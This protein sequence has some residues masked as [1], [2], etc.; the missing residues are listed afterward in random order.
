MVYCPL[1]RIAFFALAL[2]MATPAWAWPPLF[3]PEFTF[4]NPEIEAGSKDAKDVLTKENSRAL[5]A[6]G[7]KAKAMCAERGGCSVITGKDKHGPNYRIT[8]ED[9]F[10]YQVGVDTH[11]LEVQTKPGT[12]A[13]FKKNRARL[14]TDVFEFAAAQGLKPHERL[15]AGHFN[16]GIESGFGDD[17]LLFRNYLVEQ[18][19]HPEFQLG[20]FGIHKGN[21]PTLSDQ[22]EKMQRDFMRV[23]DEYDKK[24][25]DMFD[26]V[27]K[28]ES[29][30][31]TSNPYDWEPARSYQARR[32]SFV[33]P[34]TQASERRIEERGVRPQ[35]S[36]DDFIL[37]CEFYEAQ[38]A[39][40]RRLTR[41]SQ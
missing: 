30:V 38:L 13:E 40:S 23:I 12:T 6:W 33:S 28:V 35:R 9:G 29:K 14:Q 22:G 1:N 25:T 19:N 26:L 15:G 20:V 17:H 3:G 36:I 10:W 27:A 8:Y 16:I 4:T 37:Q 41:R 11:V 2:L 18:A 21:A 34:H 32:L 24:P 5:E 7:S 31:Y 39:W